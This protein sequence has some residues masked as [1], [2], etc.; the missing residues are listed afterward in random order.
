VC[1][2]PRNLTEHH[3]HPREYKESFPLGP[4]YINDLSN[5]AILCNGCHFVVHNPKPFKLIL[6][7]CE[8][9][10]REHKN[11]KSSQSAKDLQIQQEAWIRLLTVLKDRELCKKLD[12][13]RDIIRVIKGIKKR[14]ES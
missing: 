11:P 4:D 3:I 14:Y 7:H 10:L 1:L 9:K 13:Y 6:R 8:Q 5:L 2:H 12:Y